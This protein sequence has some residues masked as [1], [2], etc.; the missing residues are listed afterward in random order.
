MPALTLKNMPLQLL[1]VYFMVLLNDR[2]FSPHGEIN[3][4]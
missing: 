3:G 4:C 2:R 1:L